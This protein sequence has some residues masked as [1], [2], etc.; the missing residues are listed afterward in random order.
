M[1]FV[2]SLAV[3]LPVGVGHVHTVAMSGPGTQRDVNGVATVLGT[4]V[5]RGCVCVWQPRSSDP[6]WLPQRV[7]E[8]REGEGT[9]WWY[10]L[11]YLRRCGGGPFAT[12]GLMQHDDT[13][14]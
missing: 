10:V 4:M 12:G 1:L 6:Q 11:V 14:Q 13:P 9:I 3:W 2:N 8:A 5:L 7:G